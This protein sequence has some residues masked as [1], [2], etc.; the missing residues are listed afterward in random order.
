MSR[1]ESP[2]RTTSRECPSRPERSSHRN[3]LNQQGLNPVRRLFSIC[4][5]ETISE[6]KYYYHDFIDLFDENYPPLC[7][8]PKKRELNENEKYDHRD[9]TKQKLF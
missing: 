3:T 9:L 4:F 8:A 2:V 1:F 7:R 6:E 5:K